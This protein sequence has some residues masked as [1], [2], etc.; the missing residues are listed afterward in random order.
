MEKEKELIWVEKEF[1][2]KYKLIE[3]DSNKSEERLKI[4]NEYMTTVS[5]K[6]KAEYKANL[7]NLEEDLAIYNG[8]M[9]KVK[10]SFEKAKNEQL[11]ASYKLWENFEKEIPSIEKKVKLLQDKLSPLSTELEKI[12]NIIDNIKIYDIEKL[13]KITSELNGYLS[14]E[15]NTSNILK[16]LFENYKYNSNKTKK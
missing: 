7:E 12:K 16:F 3:N 4:F 8:L 6:S 14:Y 13:L 2:E 10:Q 15:N 11:D 5:E 1:A 9:L